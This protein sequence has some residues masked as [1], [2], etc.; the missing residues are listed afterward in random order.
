MKI[1]PLNLYN[2]DTVASELMRH[3]ADLS[4]TLRRMGVK[5]QQMQSIQL[6]GEKAFDQYVKGEVK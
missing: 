1:P 2:Y 5:E 3:L 4:G 6:I